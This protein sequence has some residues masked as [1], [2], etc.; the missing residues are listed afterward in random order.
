MERRP[1]R[2]GRPADRRPGHAGAGR[3]AQ[4]AVGRVPRAPRATATPRS[5]PCA[6]P[7]RPTRTT[8]RPASPWPTPYLNAGRMEDAL[9]EYQAAAKSPFAGLGVQVT[10]RQPAA[11]V[12]PRV[13]RPGRRVGGDRGT[14]STSSGEQHPG[15]V[16]PAVL[17]AE[18]LAARGDFA[19]AERL[20]R[21]QKAGRPG[22]LRLLVCPGGHRRP[23]PGDVRGRPGREPGTARGRRVGRV[24]AGPRPRLGRR[25]SAGPRAAAGPT[26]RAARRPPATPTV[27]GCWPDSPTCT[28]SIRDDAGRMR[29]L[30]ELAEPRRTGRG[31]AEG[32]VRPGPARRRPGGADRWRDELSRAEGPAG[33]SAAVLEALQRGPAAA[34][35]VPDRKLADWHELAPAG[36]G[37]DARTA[38]T[39]TCCWPSWPNAVA[40]RPRRPG[41]SRRPPT[42][43]RRASSV[44]G[45]ARV[46]PPARWPGRRGPPDARPPGSR[47]ACRPAGSGRSSK[48]RFAM[49]GPG[50]PVQVPVL[51]GR[52]PQAGAAVGRLGRPAA[53]RIRRKSDAIALYRQATETFPAFADGWS[54]RLLAAARLGEAE[55][56][57][58]MALAAKALDRPAFFG[59]CAECGAAVRARVPELGAAGYVG[60]R[61]PRLRRGLYRRLRGARPAGSRRSRRGAGDRRRHDVRRLS[62][63]LGLDEAG[64]SGQDRARPREARAA[65]GLGALPAPHD[66]A[67]PPRLRR[68]QAALRGLR[69]RRSLPEPSPASSARS[70]ASARRA[71]RCRLC[72]A[73][74][75]PRARPAPR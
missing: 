59:V 39:P 30:A 22:D 19:G 8:W 49:G 13:G 74:R 62:Q 60:R 24:A 75:R 28:R 68:A 52:P 3:P 63:R 42:S 36:A 15:S 7:W 32:P 73:G 66:L 67:R 1:R 18:W 69:A 70:R 12:G 11:V 38:P 5:R 57:E 41:S 6:G 21:E 35:A 56:N 55:V 34:A 37:G 61:P 46:L 58:T 53:G 64:G 25:L 4:P 45:A 33:K 72:V 20:L 71:R 31:L 10:L 26:R 65:R 14:A 29:V 9:K 40:T 43:T 50:C 23:G 54:A 48:G 47:P 16:E 2:T 17:R 27:P 51:A 44:Q